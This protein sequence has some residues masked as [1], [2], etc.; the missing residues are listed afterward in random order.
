[1]K[2]VVSALN[3]VVSGDGTEVTVGMAPRSCETGKAVARYVSLWVLS[4]L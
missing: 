2:N 3:G 1:M 4:R